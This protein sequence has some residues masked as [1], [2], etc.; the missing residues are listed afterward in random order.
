[1]RSTG[2][3]RRTGGGY[4]TRRALRMLC[5]AGVLATAGAARARADE[6]EIV[7]RVNGTPITEA[8]VNQ[9]VRS[10]IVQRGSAPN[11][12]EIAQLSDAALD[13]LIDLELLYQAAQKVPIRVTDQEVQA[14]IA[15]T[16]A[17][18][19]GDKAFAAA[20][21]RSG[22]SPSQLAAETRKTLMVDRLLAQH[23]PQDVRTTPEAARSFYDQHRDTFQHGEQ[24]RIRDLV[25]RIAAGAPPADR[26]KA[27]QL[28]DDLHGQLHSEA[29]FTRFAATYAADDAAAARGGDRGFV[30]RGALPPALDG[31]VF[32][33]P[34]GQVS[35]VIEAPD[36]YHVIAVIERRPAGLVPFEDA[37]PAVEQTLAELERRRLQQAYV[38][39]LR[40]AATIDRPRA[41]P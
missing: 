10:L 1:M 26:T 38:D 2:P 31:A 19:G 35:Q 32:S 22:L 18:L 6:L 17:Q 37:R 13:S 34:I 28:A 3:A 33:L 36:G 39:E 8:M 30:D 16:K 25:V 20:L 11:S 40:R 21:Q 15:R 27:R 14:E 29:D 23:V 5:L 41:H 9:V 12:D 4:G 24:A 7:A